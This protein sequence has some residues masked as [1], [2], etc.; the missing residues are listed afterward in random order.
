MFDRAA[1]HSLVEALPDEALDLTFRVLEH[2]QKHPPN[3]ESDPKKLRAKARNRVLRSA[4]N[5]ARRTGV[6]VPGL[7]GGC[8]GPDG[9]GSAS[10]QGWEGQTCLVSNVVFY[11]GHELHT[12]DRLSLSEDQKKL[13]Y[14]VQAQLLD[15]PAQQHEFSFDLAAENCGVGLVAGAVS[16]L[17]TVAAKLESE[18][19]RDLG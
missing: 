19:A 11:R 3:N 4:N 9:Y 5:R 2:Y 17:R 13:V 6:G 15:G 8:I 18:I 7:L 12:F 14:S 1:L 10:A 16:S